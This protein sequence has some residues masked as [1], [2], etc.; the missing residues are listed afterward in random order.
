MY[1]QLSVEGILDFGVS[2]HILCLINKDFFGS[3]VQNQD[4]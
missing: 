4:M 3:V 2:V 1:P